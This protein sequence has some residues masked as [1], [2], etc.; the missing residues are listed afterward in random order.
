MISNEESQIYQN[1]E[2][3]KVYIRIRPFSREELI[4]GKASPI[5]SIDLIKNKILVQ[6]DY[7][8]DNYYFDKILTEDST[9]NEV[10]EATTKPLLYV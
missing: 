6:K 7:E 2:P 3:I 1:Q 4:K 9:Q 10:F 5:E 8:K